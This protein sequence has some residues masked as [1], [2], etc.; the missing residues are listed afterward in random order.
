[1]DWPTLKREVELRTSRSSGSGGQHVNKVDSRVELVF[2]PAESAALSEEEK[3]WIQ[4]HLGK[5]LTAAGD[6]LV[7]SQA[8]RSQ[9]LN[10]HRAWQKLENLIK[11][12][13]HPPRPPRKA[14]AFKASR[15]KRL[16]EK[17]R[18]SET[19]SMRQ[20]PRW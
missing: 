18:R 14:T 8:E 9:H 17:R 13:L 15:K 11:S 10:R 1:M 20:N 5:R 2:R 4:H 7:S 3:D 19:K 16:D 6:L 12:A